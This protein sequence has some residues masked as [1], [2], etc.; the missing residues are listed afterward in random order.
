MFLSSFT[1]YCRHVI[2]SS[3]C[4]VKLILFLTCWVT[5]YQTCS[6][7]FWRLYTPYLALAVR[8]FRLFLCCCLCKYSCT[9]KFTLWHFNISVQSLSHGVI[10]WSTKM[11]VLSFF[12]KQ[13]FTNCA[14]ILNIN[15]T[16]VQ[17]L[18]QICK[19]IFGITTQ[20]RVRYC[21][22]I[23]NRSINKNLILSD[24]L[25]TIWLNVP[26]TF[27][28]LA[29]MDPRWISHAYFIACQLAD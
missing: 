8:R 15:M 29:E 12:I 16:A 26:F 7:T 23:Y 1:V 3:D 28:L 13:Y 4:I 5:R 20:L 27:V 25:D 10:R 9:F 24:I 19:L 14:V 11:L 17:P 6:F 2:R 21:F 22:T 18:V